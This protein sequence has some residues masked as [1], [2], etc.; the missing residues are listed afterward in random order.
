MLDT[1]TGICMGVRRKG[2]GGSGSSKLSNRYV[3]KHTYIIE[4]ISAQ[5]IMDLKLFQF[6]HGLEM[7][8]A[9]YDDRDYGGTH[10][11]YRYDNTQLG[12][13]FGFDTRTGVIVRH[14][15]MLGFHDN[16]TPSAWEEGYFG[17]KGVDSHSVGK[18]GVGVH[19]SVEANALD[20]TDLFSPPET[21][22]VSGAQ[23]KDL[24][25]LAPGESVTNC[26]LLSIATSNSVLFAGVDIDIRSAGFT[27]NGKF[28]VLSGTR[29]CVGVVAG[30][31]L[32][33]SFGTQCTVV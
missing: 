1:V 10:G 30:T 27:T 17:K 21:R 31:A 11:A 15:D 25:D 6:M 12:Q 20:N 7:D 32:L 5:P 8:T 4:N 13:S 28:R 2:A 23:R 33:S 26:V 14:N 19:L 3:F 22:W 29:L 16:H 24:G 18:P 9:I